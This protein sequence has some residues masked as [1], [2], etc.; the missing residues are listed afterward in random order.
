[1]Y[2]KFTGEH[3]K[4]IAR[5]HIVST[6]GGG[7]TIASEAQCDDAA[8]LARLS[9][10]RTGETLRPGETKLTAAQFKSEHRRVALLSIVEAVQDVEADL[11]VVEQK[12]AEIEGANPSGQTPGEAAVFTYMREQATRGPKAR[13]KKHLG[14]LEQL[15]IDRIEVEAS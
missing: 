6:H 11:A 14:M 7:D 5:R 15:E 8:C 12:L 4:V 2:I 3:E 10:L 9:H 1:M 13:V